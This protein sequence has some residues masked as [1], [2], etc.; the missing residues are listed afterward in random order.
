MPTNFLYSIDLT[1]GELV[2]EV[3]LIDAG[4]ILSLSAE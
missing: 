1:T 2:N 3:E 4:L